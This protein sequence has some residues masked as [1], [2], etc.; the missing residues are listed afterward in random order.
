MWHVKDCAKA[1]G[2]SERGVLW[3]LKRKRVP[4]AYRADDRNGTWQIP[5]NSDKPIAKAKEVGK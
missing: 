1:W 2:I 5:E 3:H 4:G